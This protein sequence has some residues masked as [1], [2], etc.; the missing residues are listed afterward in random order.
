MTQTFD[1]KRFGLC[2][3][4]RLLDPIM[5]RYTLIALAMLAPMI[6]VS[7]TLGT[8]TMAGLM[9]CG[10]PMFF[11]I[12][13]MSNKIMD[14]LLPATAGEKFWSMVVVSVTI[15]GLFFGLVMLTGA[16]FVDNSNP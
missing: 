7:V 9:G 14:T 10:I 12:A 4:Y 5:L 13:M 15:I 8:M 16:L 2:L 11:G 1:I 6:V 3:K